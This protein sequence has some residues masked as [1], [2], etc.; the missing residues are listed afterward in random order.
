M[1]KK[2]TK[3]KK[4]KKKFT[5]SAVVLIGCTNVVFRIKASKVSQLGGYR[6]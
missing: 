6:E 4:K 5:R 3:K 1:N 2:N